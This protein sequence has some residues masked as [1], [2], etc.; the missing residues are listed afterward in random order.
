MA[1][2][3]HEIKIQALPEKTFKALSNLNDLKGWHTA[4]MDGKPELNGTLSFNGIGKPVFLWKVIEL[5][6]NKKVVWECIEGP[7]DSVG[8]KATYTLSK[9]ADERTL[10]ELSH[11]SWPDQQG[12][13]R[14]C[15][16]L[17]GILL[18]HLKNYVETG[19]AAPAIS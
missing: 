4:H 17:W 10:V 1:D 6:P 14:K 15:N 5:E 13:F 9:T 18:H 11:T 16:T 19:K 7:G 8:T 12:N 3:N 2:I